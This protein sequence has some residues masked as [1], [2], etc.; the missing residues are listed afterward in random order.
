MS[1]EVMHDQDQNLTTLVV[2]GLVSAEE[3]HLAL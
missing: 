2:D 1:I 3:M